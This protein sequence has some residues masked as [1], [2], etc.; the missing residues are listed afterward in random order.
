MIYHDEAGAI[1]YNGFAGSYAFHTKLDRHYTLSF[2]ASFG[3]KEFRLDGSKL[4]FVQTPDDPEVD[5]Q[6]YSD[7]MPDANIGMWLYSEKMFFGLAARN[8]LQSGIDI[9]TTDQVISGDYSKLHNHYFVTG[10]TH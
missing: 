7:V 5:N 6:V 3:M 1:S 9:S 8:I 10:F 4:D 2:G